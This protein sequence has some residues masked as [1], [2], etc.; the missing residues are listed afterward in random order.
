MAGLPL[1][2]SRVDTESD[3]G[4]AAGAGPNACASPVASAGYRPHGPCTG[5]SF[6]AHR[7]N[8]EY[9]S[10]ALCLLKPKILNVDFFSN[11]KPC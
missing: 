6:D 5:N 9:F 7:R 8:P 3:T 10:M 2:S 4:A 1:T 11:L